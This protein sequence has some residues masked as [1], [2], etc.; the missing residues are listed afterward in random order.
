M[1]VGVTKIGC[2]FRARTW[3]ADKSVYLGMFDTEAEATQAVENA[4]RTAGLKATNSLGSK[5]FPGSSTNAHKYIATRL[6]CGGTREVYDVSLPAKTG[7]RKQT[8][9]TTAEA[10]AHVT[11]ETGMTSQQ[12]KRKYDGVSQVVDALGRFKTTSSIF[13]GWVPADLACAKRLRVGDHKAMVLQAP[14]LY[15]FS[16]LAKEDPLREI[17]VSAWNALTDKQKLPL[18]GLLGASPEGLAA[19]QMHG[20]FC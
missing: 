4:R 2:K 15:C 12:L 13:S 17:L 16:L 18:P 11:T 5:P 3:V 6:A 8:F 14:V 10:L 19:C 9:Q 1:P 7:A 20:V